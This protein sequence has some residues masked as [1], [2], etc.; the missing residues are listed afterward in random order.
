MKKLYSVFVVIIININL[1]YPLKYEKYQKQY[2]T[3]GTF[4]TVTIFY[5]DEKKAYELLDNCYEISNKLEN[6]ISCRKPDTI[7]SNL[8]K[9][10]SMIINDNF[11]YDLIK[12]AINLSILTNGAFD[13]A[14]YSI[15]KLWGVDTENPKVPSDD[16][17]RE[18]LK[19]SGYKNIK[20]NDF[21]NQVVLENNIMLDLGGIAKVKIIGEIAKYLLKEGVVDFIVNGGG[22]LI[23]NGFYG[24]K[25][26]WKVAITDPFEQN[27]HIG[28]I[29][30]TN[31]RVVTSGD[32]QR[33]FIDKDGKKYHH[34]MDPTTGKPV[35]NGIHS[36]TV[37]TD[38]PLKAEG[39]SAGIFVLG[40]EKGLQLVKKLGN[41]GVIII[42]GEK[43][44]PVI[45]VSDNI[46]YFKNK[47]N[48]LNFSYKK[49]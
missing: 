27:K 48:I 45:T 29:S 11:V 40:I 8:N 14:L 25:R 47:D 30:L 32:Y 31:C 35:D 7:I 16:E 5:T 18:A 28:L 4:L 46:T 44:N 37:I 3:M 23:V 24:N 39:M 17:I 42:S 12:Q 33:F 19:K 20:L 49:E 9:N 2:F 21:N 43:N 15:I 10:K 1:V 41:V 22:D 13:P 26:K 6:K 36:V 34:I 38:D